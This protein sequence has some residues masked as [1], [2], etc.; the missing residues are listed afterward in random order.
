[1][2]TLEVHDDQ[3]RVQFVELVRDHPALFGT[4]AACDVVLSG[5]DIRPVHG[6]ILWRRTRFRIEASP[7]AEFVEVNGTKMASSSLHQGDEVRVGDCRIYMFRVDEDLGGGARR[8]S[9]R[10]G[11]DDATRV[12]DGPG[13]QPSHSGDGGGRGGDEKTRVLTRPSKLES[14]AWLEELEDVVPHRD[15][16]DNRGGD[17]TRTGGPGADRSDRLAGRLRAWVG[18]LRDGRAQ[19]PGRERVVSSPLVLGLIA[20]LL[21]LIAVGIGLRSIILKSQ[22][23]SSFNRAVELMEDGDYRNA[24]RDFDAFLA[25]FPEDPRAG[26][27]RVHR[28]MANVRQY[29]SVSGGT[30]S[31]ALEAAREMLAGVGAEPAFRDSRPELADQVIRIGEGL[32]DRARRSADEK[33]LREAESVVSLHAEI[34]GESA[35]A[36]LKKSRLPDLLN[37]ARA[38]VHKSKVRAASLAAMDRALQDGS[39]SRVYGARDSLIAQYAD[40]A[41]DRD[42]IQRMTGAND[43]VKKAVTLDSQRRAANTD[44]HPDVLGPA[45][46]LVLRS[47]TEAPAPVQAE[48]LFHGLADGIAYALDANTGAAIWQRPVG[49]A[50]PF[51]PVP[52]AGDPSVLVAD[53]RYDELLRLDAGTG[54]LLWRLPL[55]EPI[56]SPPLVLGNDLFQALPRGKLLVAS[57]RTGEVQ[58]TL[59]LGMAIAKAPVTDEQGRFLYLLGRRDCLFILS[60][61]PLACIGV[62]YLGHDDG[63]IA[64]PPARIGR[65]LIAVEN[66]LPSDSSWRVMVLDDDGAKVRPVQRVDVGGWQWD[67]PAASG[68]ILWAAGD[69]GGVE[70][71]ALG[72]Y[73]SS[74]P[75]HSLARSN[76]DRTSG[77]P[78]FGLALTERELWLG[79]VRSGRYDLEAERGR[80]AA[81]FLLGPLGPATAPIRSASGGRVVAITTQ[82]PA[83]G[84]TL[85]C[86]VDP[87]DGSVRW[88]TILGAPWPT[89]LTPTAR[90]DGLRTIGESG[91]ETIL[92][93][94]RLEAGGF[95]FL[96]MSRP[97]SARLQTAGRLVVLEGPGEGTEVVAPRAGGS[98]VWAR[99][100]GKQGVE[101]WRK[102]ELPT[103]LAAMPLAWGPNLLIPGVDGRVYLIDPLTAESRAEPFVPVYDRD[104]RGRWLAPAPIDATSAILAD[105][106]GRVRRLVLRADPSPRLVAE[107]ETLLDRGIVAEPAAT[108]GA[109]VVVTADGMARALSIRDLSPIGS[110]PLAAPIVDRPFVVEGHGFLAD[111][112]GGVL[113]LRKDGRKAWS[114][115]L[116]SPPLGAPVVDGDL[117]WFLDRDGILHGRSLG[118]GSPRQKVDLRM[119]PA[120]GLLAVGGRT[121][122][123]V[124]RGTLRPIDLKA[125]LG[126]KP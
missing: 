77:G 42:L 14:P 28:A 78:A 41:H 39:A 123:P 111:A 119:I 106:I 71:F 52:V 69:K 29:I 21:S 73:T 97:G 98:V 38:A 8:R 27:A 121:F 24:M 105:D 117:A 118:D 9:R 45:T 80:I 104:R 96:P 34:A 76:P 94:R 57:L 5:R 2:A 43:L 87:K 74:S 107:A 68:S 11:Q 70:A 65:F 56:E 93:T 25:A 67:T 30:W 15:D 110:W 26:K 17:T 84:G 112:S 89:S 61:D 47:T 37:E 114:I 18:A 31:T 122:V 33:S 79:G 95:E 7:D 50:A 40:L 92:P 44:D 10:H 4:S 1:M 116:E 120:G 58:E 113:A 62:A 48:S 100:P 63:S 85:L 3:G 75:L 91:D 54:K 125:L 81:K 108:E 124:A 83:T 103:A 35:T 126:G 23:E 53:A 16:Q 82:D 102:V 20:A 59:D 60:R 109:A 88:R 49:L 101:A 22:A 12:V 64:C 46:S 19:A 13:R 36:F 55:G 90:R 51:P 6:R 86:G 32:A 99:L 115:P 72:D 66:N